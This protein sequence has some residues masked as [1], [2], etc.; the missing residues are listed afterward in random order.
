MVLFLEEDTGYLLVHRYA[1]RLG[2]QIDREDADGIFPG[3]FGH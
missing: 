3:T 1:I 2:N